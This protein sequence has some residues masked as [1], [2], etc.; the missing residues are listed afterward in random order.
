MA[1]G[2]VATDN[3]ITTLEVAQAAKLLEKGTPKNLIQPR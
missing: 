1:F 3:Q 2:R